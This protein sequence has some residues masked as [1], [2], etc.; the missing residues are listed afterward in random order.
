MTSKNSPHPPIVSRA[1]WL[2]ARRWHLLQEKRVTKEHD[3]VNA[4]RRRLPM[5]KLAK[6]YVFNSPQGRRS[7]RDLFAGRRQLIVYHFMFD[8]KWSQGCPGCT[9]YVDALG[10][11]SMLDGRN[12]TFALISRAPLPSF[13]PTR[14]NAAGTGLPGCRRLAAIL[15]TTFTPRSTKR[16]RR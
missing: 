13:A 1:Q 9:G 4:E 10:D 15:T 11:L 3:R 6:E 14:R 16:W 7:L 8:P 5:V 2:A 12:T